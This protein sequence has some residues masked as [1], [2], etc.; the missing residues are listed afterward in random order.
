MTLLRTAVAL[1]ASLALTSSVSAQFSVYGPGTS[2]PSAGTGGD[3]WNVGDGGAVY[4]S[5]QPGLHSA[6][7]VLIPVPVTTINALVI[8]GLQHSFAGDLQ[9]TLLDPVGGEYL[10][11]LRPGYQN[12]GTSGMAADF[13][14]NYTFIEFGGQDLP[15]DSAHT[16]DISAGVYNQT[17]S[18]GGVIWNNGAS[19]I[20]NVAM[21]SIAAPSGNWELRI[22]DWSTGEVGSFTDWELHGNGP[23]ANSG[24]G[25]CFGS[26]SGA[27]CPCSGFGGSTT[28]CANT[29][30][31]GA[32]LFATGQ[33][34]IVAD[35]FSLSL[36]GVPSNKPGLILRGANQL[37][38]GLGNPVGDGLLCTG[39]QTG[40]SQ[41]QIASAGG[42]TLFTDFQGGTF[43][44]SSYGPGAVTNYQF[45]YRDTGN[46]C[47]AGFNFSNA[48]TVIWMP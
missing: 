25:Y 44:A 31:A 45:W 13:N 17:F 29:S 35:T 32:E 10:I 34:S 42:E 9:V 33:A 27:S 23:Q 30:G 12:P 22:Y 19:H 43:G 16:S 39:G 3:S 41:V 5:Q 24:T 46:T 8:N 11:F 4:D 20:Q 21:N 14:G 38:A 6:S 47:G 28:G 15:N 26:G 36:R 18:S 40:R 7:Q 37:N 1:A 48:W 2:I